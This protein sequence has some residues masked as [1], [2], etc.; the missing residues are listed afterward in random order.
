MQTKVLQ[1][2]AC[3]LNK[4]RYF[5]LSQRNGGDSVGWRA[6][7]SHI[8]FWGPAP[9]TTVLSRTKLRASL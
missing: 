3:D 5:S 2:S 6:A 1:Q 4:V 7:L 9:S 8:L